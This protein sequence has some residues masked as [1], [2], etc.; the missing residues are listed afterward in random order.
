MLVSSPL[1]EHDNC[2]VSL[3]AAINGKPSR[4][5]VGIARPLRFGIEE[6]LMLMV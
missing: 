6:L 1:W 5:V 4:A 3:V 2:G